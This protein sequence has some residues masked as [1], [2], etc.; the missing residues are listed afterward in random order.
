MNDENKSN[1]SIL[2]D[3]PINHAHKKSV[4]VDDIIEIENEYGLFKVL[5][6]SSTNQVTAI[7]YRGY[8]VEI[9]K[10]EIRYNHK[11]TIDL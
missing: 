8:R 9:P 1:Y 11:N 4:A 2:P 7:D 5:S 6:V 10:R 3:S